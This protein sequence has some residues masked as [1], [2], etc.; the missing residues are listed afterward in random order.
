MSI[1]LKNLKQRE[2][3]RVK[4]VWQTL[5]ATFAFVLLRIS[6]FC[7]DVSVMSRFYITFITSCT[8]LF[9]LLISPHLYR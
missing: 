8:A 3:E 4:R 9:K 7:T 5:L 2:H 1:K 6:S